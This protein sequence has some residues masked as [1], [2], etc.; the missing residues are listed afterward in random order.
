M[1]YAGGVCL[2]PEYLVEATYLSGVIVICRATSRAFG[3]LSRQSSG[4][5]YLGDRKTYPCVG[6]GVSH[7]RGFEAQ[8][9]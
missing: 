5:S 8:R 3:Y 7:R 6:H 4:L 1:I 2:L 9:S